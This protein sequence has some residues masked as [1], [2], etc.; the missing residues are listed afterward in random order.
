MTPPET[1][2]HHHAPGWPDPGPL[3][4]FAA[5][6]ARRAGEP[7][8]ND[9]RDDESALLTE[10]A[11]AGRRQTFRLGR[12]AAH[13]A[14]RGLDRDR[15]PILSGP[16]RDPVW[17]DGI[18]G[19]ISHVPHLG[20]ALVASAADTDGVGID[21]EVHGETPELEGQVPRP[22][23]L[24][25]LDR[26]APDDRQRLL[27]ALFSAKESLFKAFYPRVGTFFGFE[28]AALVPAPNGFTAR[29]VSGLD[30]AYP[31]QRTFHIHCAWTDE[32]VLTWLILPRTPPAPPV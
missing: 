16:G 14:L 3:P 17:P 9:F 18:V 32:M 1:D 10:R 20:V 4:A 5:F 30:A 8:D 11:V 19:S 6:A 31:R 28:A 12:A 29:L 7:D 22:E 23:E 15:A 21:I 26:A 27:L 25:W 24:S 13:A 2:H